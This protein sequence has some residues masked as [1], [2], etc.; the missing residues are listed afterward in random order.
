MELTDAMIEG[1]AWAIIEAQPRATRLDLDDAW[2]MAKAALEAVI[3]LM[4]NAMVRAVAKPD[5]ERAGHF[6]PSYCRSLDEDAPTCLEPCPDCLAG[7]SRVITAIEPWL[8]ADIAA[9]LAAKGTAE[10]D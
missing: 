5:D 2:P 10:A 4:Q 8:R 7:V 6:W 1:A 3:P 9:E